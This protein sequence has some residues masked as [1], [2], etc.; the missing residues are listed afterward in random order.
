MRPRLIPVLQIMNGSLVK[1]KQF[2][3]YNYIGDPLNSTKI[4][5]DLCVDELIVLDI[6]I[7]KFAEYDIDWQLVESLAAECF[8]PLTYG[9][10]IKKVSDAKKLINIGVEKIVIN[11]QAHFGL[12]IIEDIS[13]CIGSSSTIVSID[14]RRTKDGYQL[15]SHSGRNKIDHTLSDW[16][17]KLEASGVGEIMINDIDREGTWSGLDM[18]LLKLVLN[19]TKLPVIYSGGTSSWAEAQKIISRVDIGAIGVGNAAVY[20]KQLFGVLINYPKE[21]SASYT[22]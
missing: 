14:V 18:E 19:L 11:S 15:Y 6:G 20:Q 13:N 2:A 16:I 17:S 7:S 10:G 12:E 9:G 22:M 5:N 4:F 3:S 8:M 21:I 1:T